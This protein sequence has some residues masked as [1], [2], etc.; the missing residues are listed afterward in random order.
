MQSNECEHEVLLAAYVPAAGAGRL[1]EG[2]AVS[3][4]HYTASALLG[5]VRPDHTPADERLRAIVQAVRV[6]GPGCAAVLPLLYAADPGWDWA[7]HVTYLF[8][9]WDERVTR[10]RQLAP[11]VLFCELADEAVADLQQA[12]REVAAAAELAEAAKEQLDR[13]AR[14]VAG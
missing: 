11:V 10:A 8:E 4:D 9:A 2:Y 5:V 14:M 6:A 3:D 13:L 7:A 12:E 1:A